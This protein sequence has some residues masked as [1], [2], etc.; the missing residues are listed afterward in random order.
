MSW[1]SFTY[2]FKRLL[3]RPRAFWRARQRVGVTAA[4]KLSLIRFGKRDKIYTVKVPQWQHPVYLRGG[5]SSD[6]MVL[7]EIL[8]TD[9]YRPIGELDRPKFIIDGGANIGLFSVYML[10]LYPAA[11]LVVV[12]PDSE[13]MR[14]CQMNLKLYGTRTTLLQRAI[15]SRSGSLVLEPSSLEWSISVRPPRE[16]ETASLEAST[17]PEL[18]AL[19]GGVVDLLKLDIEGAELEV[20]GGGSQDWLPSVKNIAVELHTPAC[21]DQFFSAMNPYE[22][23][24]SNQDNV[25]VCRNLHG[26]LP[27]TSPR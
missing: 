14:L 16:G 27:F 25:Y 3:T 24:M 12:E 2:H 7:Y 9:E 15:W 22:Y 11:Q 26:T 20:F 4:I 8:V 5:L 17:V 18:I 21:V 6:S 23:E 19:G 10:N 13:N 1:V